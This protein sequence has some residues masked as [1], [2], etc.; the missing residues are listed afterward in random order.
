MS[1]KFGK[2]G[3]EMLQK[4]SEKHKMS[5]WNNSPKVSLFLALLA[6][7]LDLGILGHP[8]IQDAS[9]GVMGLITSQ[10]P[11]G[12]ELLVPEKKKKKQQHGFQVDICYV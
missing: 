6:L 3:L 8:T 2:F 11:T 12:E 5:G 4:K 7:R 9:Q 10:F 1:E